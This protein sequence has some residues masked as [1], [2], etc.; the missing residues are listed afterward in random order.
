MVNRIIYS[1]AVLSFFMQCTPVQKN[2][3]NSIEWKIA[4]NVP[5]AEGAERALGLAGPVAGIYNDVLMVGGGANFPGA[6]PWMGGAKEYYDI[7]YAYT[8]EYDSFAFLNS[9]KLPMT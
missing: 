3:V 8:L 1:I 5:A 9:F 6:M 7:G 2:Q 4:A